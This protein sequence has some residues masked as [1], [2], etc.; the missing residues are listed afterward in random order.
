MLITP[1]SVFKVHAASRATEFVVT[2]YLGHCS[3]YSV[4]SCMG[5][6]C[7]NGLQSGFRLEHNSFWLEEATK[8]YSFLKDHCAC[9]VS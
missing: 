2:G 6:F 3:C 1:T 5:V 4:M 8:Q 7:Y 9:H